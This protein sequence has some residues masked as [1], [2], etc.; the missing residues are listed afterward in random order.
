[1]L[2]ISN[3]HQGS[4]EK[5]GKA[6]NWSFEIEKIN[7]ERKKAQNLILRVVVIEALTLEGKLCWV[8]FALY[9]RLVKWRIVFSICFDFG[10]RISI[11]CR[12]RL[13]IFLFPNTGT[14]S[15][16]TNS[17]NIVP[18]VCVLFVFDFWLLISGQVHNLLTNL[19]I[20][21]VLIC[22]VFSLA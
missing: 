10:F 14:K 20:M 11:I 2:F 19:I 22:S 1:M 3:T 5:I 16:Q 15:A 8:C 9:I 6:Q 12:S 13:L 4:A 18:R 21:C 17:Q 7:G